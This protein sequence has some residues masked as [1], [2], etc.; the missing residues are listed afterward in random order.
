VLGDHLVD[1]IGGS[2]DANAVATATTM[3][4][5]RKTETEQIMV[6]YYSDP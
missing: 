4:T 5:K 1:L 3:V 2:D 6:K